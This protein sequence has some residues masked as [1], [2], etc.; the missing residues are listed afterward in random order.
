MIQSL[1]KKMIPEKNFP[2]PTLKKLT[3]Q[4]YPPEKYIVRW[5]PLDKSII[6]GPLGFLRPYPCKDKK[7]SNLLHNP[8]WTIFHAPQKDVWWQ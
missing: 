3:V 4:I 5:K 8:W 1:G 2:S 6:K 7:C